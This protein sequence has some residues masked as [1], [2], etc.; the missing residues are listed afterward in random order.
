MAI[1]EFPNAQPG[2]WVITTQSADT[3]PA[4]AIANNGT[5]AALTINGTTIFDA[6]GNFKGTVS[7]ANPATISVNSASYAL[8]LANAGAGGLI[9]GASGAFLV[10]NSGN[11]TAVHGVLSSGNSTAALT[12]TSTSTGNM[13]TAGNFTVTSAGSITMLSAG[14]VT[15]THGAATA[16]SNA[17]TISAAYGEYTTASLSTAAGASTTTQTIT[18][19]SILSTSKV[20]FN[21]ITG[22]AT[23]GVMYAQLAAVSAGSFTFVLTNLGANAANGTFVVQFLVV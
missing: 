17:G 16:S 7:D 19:T 5:G 22:T 23:A 10:D 15:Q 4:L 13:I 1:T 12:I 6:T 8:T 14:L 21:V 9:T 3:V 11:L 2:P 20:F 18:N